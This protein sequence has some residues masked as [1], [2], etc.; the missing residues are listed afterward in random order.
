M[1]ARRE[2]SQPEASCGSRGLFLLGKNDETEQRVVQLLRV[3]HGR[4][5]ILASACDGFGAQLAQLVGVLWE[6][7]PENDGPG[8]TLFQRRVI[9]KS[10]GHR[11]QDLMGK[12]RRHRSVPRLKL[13]L[14]ALQGLEHLAQTFDVERFGQTVPQCFE[15][16]RV[17][18]NLHVPRIAVVLTLGLFRENRRQHVVRLHALDGRC[19]SLPASESEQG[20]RPGQRPAPTRGKRRCGQNGLDQR[21][22]HVPGFAELKDIFQRE[23]MLRRQRNIDAVVVCGSLKFQIEAAAEPFAQSQSPGAV[24]RC[25]QRGVDDELHAAAFIKEA[26][27]DDTVQRRN[28]TQYTL[29]FRNIFA[30]LFGAATR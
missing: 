30:R 11:V 5:R 29:S 25:S 24:D 17:I 27:C 28:R 8:A 18:W 2:S 16:Q 14:S 20:Q 15:N 9:E 21:V 19:N 12:G 26:L 13:D 6:R 22:S 1:L 10:I 7:A 4:P 3:A 23:G